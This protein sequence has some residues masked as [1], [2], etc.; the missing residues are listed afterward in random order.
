MSRIAI[1]ICF[2]WISFC[3][4][5]GQTPGDALRYSYWQYSGTAR[6]M[7]TSGSMGALGGDYS[8]IIS[9]PASLAAFRRSEITIT[10]GLSVYG[11]QSNFANNQIS[12]SK[13]SGNFNQAGVVFASPKEGKW[14]TVNFSLGYNRLMDFDQEFYFDGTTEGSI[15]DYFVELASGLRPENLSNYDSGLALDS[16]LIYQLDPDHPLYTPVYYEN[17]FILGDVTRK[18]QRV[19]TN[20]SL[21]ELNLALGGN[22]DHKLY[23]GMSIGI[24]FL[25]YRL[26]KNYEE[27]DEAGE[28]NFYERS[29]FTEFLNTSGVGIHLNLGAIYRVNQAIRVGVAVHTP[30]WFTL[31]DSY[32]SEL[33]FVYDNL[34]T[35]G[36]NTEESPVGTFEYKLKTP[37][38]FIGNAGFIIKKSGFIS[39]EAEWVDYSKNTYNYGSD[40][41]TQEILE[42]EQ[43]TNGKIH[44]LYQGA[45]NLKFG[46]EYV[47]KE[48]FRLR[49]GYAL[50]GNP[51]V[52]NSGMFD[53]SQFSAG[54]GYRKENY[55][56]DLGYVR[57]IGEQTYAPYVLNSEIID[58]PVVQNDTSTDQI[59]ITLGFKF[60]GKRAR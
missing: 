36:S 31:T 4:L 25:D 56:V 13:T 17:D 40:F 37:W 20:G 22:L 7:G 30:T 18:F 59:L 5:S 58:S 6:H 24:P 51:Y 12:E 26:R 50:F 16:Y 19:R 54:L 35:L 11:T 38:R 49:G 34:G 27:S 41:A 32:G 57:R 15:A 39:I 28:V 14:K 43:Y 55:F 53:N 33:T 23:L 48:K 8:A 46:G 44:S 9:N 3:N 47:I 29:S 60:G 21:G 52:N 45:L 1:V 2:F 10:P 42:I